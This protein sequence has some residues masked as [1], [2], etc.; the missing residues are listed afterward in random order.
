MIWRFVSGDHK[1]GNARNLALHCLCLW[2]EQLSTWDLSVQ[3]LILNNSGVHIRAWSP[4]P[5]LPTGKGLRLV[6]QAAGGGL[7]PG[8][9]WPR[10]SLVTG[11]LWTRGPFQ[12][13]LKLTWG[14]ELVICESNLKKAQALAHACFCKLSSGMKLIGQMGLKFRDCSSLARLRVATICERT[15]QLVNL[16]VVDPKFAQTIEFSTKFSE[17]PLRKVILLTENVF[18]LKSPIFS[19][20]FV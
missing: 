18:L 9:W 14:L 12:W 5:H 13:T 3:R 10:L 19:L 1:Q 4:T 2:G 15:W 7:G 6:S 17:T 20:S 8:S 11:K 16:R